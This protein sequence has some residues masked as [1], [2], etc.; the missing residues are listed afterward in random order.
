MK[1]AFEPG[2]KPEVVEDLSRRGHKII[3]DGENPSFGGAQLIYR[4]ADG[5]CGASDPR[6]DGQ[7]VGF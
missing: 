4:M 3:K 6:K 1:V 7:A 5:Y 2:F